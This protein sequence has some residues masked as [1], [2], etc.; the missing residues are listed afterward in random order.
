MILLIQIVSYQQ[1]IADTTISKLSQRADSWMESVKIMWLFMM[2]IGDYFT[3]QYL[4]SKTYISC[5]YVL[6]GPG[7]QQPFDWRRDLP[8]AYAQLNTRHGAV[9]GDWPGLSA[10]A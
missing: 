8:K 1:N 4:Q 7:C 6:L 9:E 10:P 3:L 2:N 5:C